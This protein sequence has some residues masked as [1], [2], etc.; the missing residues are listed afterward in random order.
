DACCVAGCGQCG[1][2][3]CHLF[4]GGL[5]ETN[6]CQSDIEDGGELCSVSGAAPC[7]VDGE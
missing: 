6:C 1:G 4:G 7:V 5:G 2:S 3:N